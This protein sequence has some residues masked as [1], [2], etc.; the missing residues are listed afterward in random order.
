MENGLNV[1]QY[2][3]RALIAGGAFH[4]ETGRLVIT[5]AQY[6]DIQSS[7][8]GFEPL[9]E[10]KNRKVFTSDRELRRVDLANRL[11]DSVNLSDPDDYLAKITEF[12]LTA[13]SSSGEEYPA[14]KVLN[15]SYELFWHSMGWSKL[16]DKI[17]KE[18]LKEEAFQHDRYGS[19]Y[20]IDSVANNLQ[21]QV[22]ILLRSIDSI[23]YYASNK[24][25][26]L[27]N[28]IRLTALADD[29]TQTSVVNS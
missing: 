14:V 18:K 22:L 24:A 10:V 9:E 3:D 20:G 28:N 8:S 7:Q 11:L 21:G 5:A 27:Y 16:V 17:D 13:S 12:A 19:I 2:Y 25:T 6:V 29:A 1:R 26:S 23:G 4:S 15:G